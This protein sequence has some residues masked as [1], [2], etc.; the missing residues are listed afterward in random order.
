MNN[1]FKIIVILLISTNSLATNW[2]SKTGEKGYWNYEII[3]KTTKTTATRLSIPKPPLPPAELPSTEKMMKMHPDQI[4]ILV[5]QWRKHAI[6]TLEPK[7]VSEYLRIQDVARKK[8]VGYA[9][10]VGLVNQKNP[11]LTLEDELPTTNT[12]MQTQYNIRKKATNNYIAKY[13]KNFGLLYF[14]STSCEYCVVQ[15]GILRQF[16]EQFNY[17]IKDVLL[18]KNPILAAKFGVKQ[19]PS[20]ILVNRRT[21]KWIP[22]SFGSIS[23]PRLKENI[24]RGIRYINKEI[25]PAQFFTNERDIGTGLDPLN[26]QNK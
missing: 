8:A 14:T 20:L 25:K 15:D 23:L 6:Y 21:K 3:T 13:S 9:A 22:V 5:S 19:T 4:K 1:F 24:Y 12:G 11:N 26:K 18:S 7:D 17:E 2:N 10:V 16:L